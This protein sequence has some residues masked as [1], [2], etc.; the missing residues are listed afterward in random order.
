MSETAREING[1]Y[2]TGRLAGARGEVE[3]SPGGQLWLA[4]FRQGSVSE[5]IEYLL[6]YSVK[7]ENHL[8]IPSLRLEGRN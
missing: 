2:F 6:A 3:A 7:D 1:L 4:H 8:E 5:Y